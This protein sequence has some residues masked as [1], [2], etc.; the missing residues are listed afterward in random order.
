MFVPAWDIYDL[1][2]RVAEEIE[3]KHDARAIRIE[4][5]TEYGN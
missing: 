3:N 1:D 2:S 5:S 4:K